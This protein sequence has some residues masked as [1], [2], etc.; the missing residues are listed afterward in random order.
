LAQQ[1]AA[2]RLQPVLVEFLCVR[3]RGAAGPGRAQRK[4]NLPLQAEALAR[5]RA[6][7]HAGRGDSHF[8][9]RS[10]PASHL[11]VS[12]NLHRREN[13]QK[14][15]V[16]FNAGRGHP[17]LAGRGCGGGDRAQRGAQACGSGDRHNRWCGRLLTQSPLSH[18]CHGLVPWSFTFVAGGCLATNGSSQRL[19]V[20]DRKCGFYGGAASPG[21][22]YRLLDSR[23]G[24]LSVHARRDL[25][26]DHELEIPEPQLH[27]PAVAQQDLE[28]VPAL[29]VH[30]PFLVEPGHQV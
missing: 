6:Y 19:G 15:V 23:L 9:L 14:T 16:S 27:R 21:S 1:P 29:A 3:W 28:P 25:L 20:S 12:A 10:G 30:I 17:S 13:T 8:A 26:H 4:P 18:G 24:K 11:P 5:H 7:G 2:A 22:S